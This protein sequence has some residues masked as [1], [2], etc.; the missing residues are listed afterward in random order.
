MAFLDTMTKQ[1]DQRI[2]VLKGIGIICVVW[3][4]LRGY[5][6][7]EIYIFHMP[8]FFFLSGMFYRRKSGFVVSRIKSLLV[9]VLFYLGLF[10]LIYWIDGG[11]LVNRI[12]R[13]SFFKPTEIDGPLWFLIS[14]FTIAVVYW[15]LDGWL[16][17]KAR[18]ALVCSVIGGVFYYWDV[19]L[20]L[21]LRQ[22]AIALP[23]YAWGAWMREKG[24]T[25]ANYN[26]KLLVGHGVVFMGVV[27]YCVV[28]N[29]RF[30][31]SS[32][33]LPDNCLLLYGG[34]LAAILLLLNVRTFSK[35][36]KM[37]ALLASYG[38][39][40]LSIMA[41]H[42]PYMFE[43]RNAV[44]RWHLF[45]DKTTNTVMTFF[46]TFFIIIISSYLM[47]LAIGWMKRRG[48]EY[49]SNLSIKKG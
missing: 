3:A 17:S 15:G 44:Y 30:D 28:N 26:W 45:A 39:H 5:F 7:M 12:D 23:F 6:S 29:F 9:P 20:P 40:S 32:L 11:R 46:I 25:N 31:I 4:H 24:W 13:T 14:L 34:A 10:A 49:F 36:N 37:N 33:Y 18:L 19:A 35:T 21:C 1:R 43:I 8:L 42:M 38:R 27:A 2:D 47:A 48:D 41:L 22:S 16:K